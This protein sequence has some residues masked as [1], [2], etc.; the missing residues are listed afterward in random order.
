MKPTWLIEAD[1]FGAAAEPLK[2]EIRGRGLDVFVV[3]HRPHAPQPRD[4]IGAEALPPEAC[5]IFVGTYPAMRHVTL[6]RKWR[7]GAWCSDARLACS[8]YYAYF[9]AHMLNQRYTILPGVEAL[10]HADRLFDSYGRDGKIFARPDA[11]QK[12]FTGAVT[13]RRGFE[14]V[15]APALYDPAT[16]VLLAEP[17]TIGREWR[18]LVA[19]GQVVAASQYLDSG[20]RLLEAGCPDE[21]RGFAERVLATVAWRPDP[22]FMMDVCESEA[23]LRIL[24]LNSFSCSGFY[25]CD[26]GA[27]VAAA[28]EAAAGLW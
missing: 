7:P 4:L 17:Q 11:V 20:Q 8:C 22:L 27:I 5:V 10:R 18:L 23:G 16:L 3:R 13:E 1:I 25:L 19:H 15:L 9:G 21:V 14:R 12:I 24:E 6:Y 28:S 26:P 2:A